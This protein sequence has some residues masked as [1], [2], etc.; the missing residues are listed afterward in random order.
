ENSAHDPEGLEEERRLMYVAITRARECLY[1]SFAQERMLHGQT[2]YSVRSRFLGEIPPQLLAWLT[3]AL[4]TRGYAAFDARP[5]PARAPA[6][7]AGGGFR[8]GQEVLHAKF[9]SGVIVAAEGSGSD[10][11][12]QVNFGRN[13]TK[14]LALA[15][16]KLDRV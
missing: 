15:I 3:P 6:A 13:G 9:G 1:L 8:I 16:A 5:A 12:V 14:W 11:R 7:A 4:G 10:A 2:R